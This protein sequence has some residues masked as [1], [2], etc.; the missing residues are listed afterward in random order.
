MTLLL[1][2]R[3]SLAGQPSTH[4]FVCGVSGYPYLENPA[5]PAARRGLDL[6]P[7]EAPSLSARVIAKW[8]IDHA[9]DLAAPLATCRL[10]AGP[11]AKHDEGLAPPQTFDLPTLDA[12]L[13]E[14]A[15]WRDDAASANENM[16]I[17]YVAGLGLLLPGA[18][19]D[20]TV[21]LYDFGTEA[22]PL[23]HNAIDTRSLFLGMA[24]GKW[25]Q[26]IAR[27]QLYFIDTGRRL[28]PPEL[29]LT[30]PP[31]VV[32]DPQIDA[33]PDDRIAV[34]FYASGPG[35]QAVAYRDQPSLFAQVL[36]EC[37]AGRAATVLDD[38]SWAVTTQELAATLPREF[39]R[40]SD[41][42][43]HDQDVMVSGLLGDE[44]IVKLGEPPL[45]SAVIEVPA[46][47]PDG[48][49]VSVRDASLRLVAEHDIAAAGDT[50]RLT[51]PAGQ[52]LVE[53]TRPG[54]KT[55]RRIGL[56]DPSSEKTSFRVD[57]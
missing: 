55:L 47:A 42:I 28:A 51:V 33:V 57:G 2:R 56:L 21:L 20:P 9:D 11:V 19:S 40:R 45:V 48:S 16:T 31:S 41:A 3:E 32:F 44:V 25:T 8:L 4:A 6:K 1:D 46:D 36:L 38:G 52:Y 27:R 49:R 22:G 53:F 30:S 14:A 50:I 35:Q 29:A 43:G 39:A 34:T 17:C 54:A 18:T 13:Y 12:F 24:P 37:L 5:G 7:V 15:N 23:L 26:K 10:I